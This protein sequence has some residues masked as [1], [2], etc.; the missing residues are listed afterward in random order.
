MNKKDYEKPAIRV[1][2]LQQQSLLLAGSV[3]AA[4]TDYGTANE[5]EW[6]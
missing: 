4:R 5:Q 3:E 2:L 6:D 1:V